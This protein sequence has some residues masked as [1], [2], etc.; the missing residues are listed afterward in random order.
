MKYF[1]K[2]LL[3]FAMLIILIRTNTVYAAEIKVY[4]IG[5]LE[6]YLTESK[7]GYVHVD[8]T[9]RIKFISKRWTNYGFIVIDNVWHELKYNMSYVDKYS[10]KGY[11]KVNFYLSYGDDNMVYLQKTIEFFVD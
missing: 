6:D 9:D 11:N 2:V 7:D 4:T 3:M 1:K 10:Y 8:S 5:D